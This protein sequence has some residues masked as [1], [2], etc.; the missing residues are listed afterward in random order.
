MKYKLVA[1][2]CD[3]TLLDQYGNISE[4]NK[5]VISRLRDMGV[6]IVIATGRNDILAKDYAEEMNIKAPIISCNGAMISDLF[7]NKV[8]LTDAVPRTA[9]YEIFAYLTTNNILFKVLTDKACY[10]NDKQ[11][12][13]QGLQ[14]ITK[15]YTR[16]L[17]YS[18]PYNFVEDMNQ[19]R[20]IKNILKI[21][22]IDDSEERRTEIV[23][24]LKKTKGVNVHT[25]GFNCIDVISKTASKG[26]ALKLYAEKKGIKREEIIAF[27]DGNNDLSMIEYAGI[28]AAMLNGDEA[29]KKAADIVTEYDNTDSGTGRELAKIF[30]LELL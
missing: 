26:S 24:E 10:T 16:V 7:N 23:T 12:M 13:E 17:K 25:A 28:G 29:L 20:D 18:I 5:K 1:L 27:G 15:N 2:D 9:V 30:G 8:Y 22:I 14:Q 3:N 6:D 4:L 21:V 19:I 11:A